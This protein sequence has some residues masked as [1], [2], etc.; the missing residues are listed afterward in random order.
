MILG[1]S[2]TIINAKYFPDAMLF[3]QVFI[4]ISI[5]FG[6]S[7]EQHQGNKRTKSPQI[8][9]VCVG[10]TS[11]FVS[12]DATICCKQIACDRFTNSSMNYDNSLAIFSKE[13]RP[14]E[15]PN[16]PERERLSEQCIFGAF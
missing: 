12:T 3:L 7:S 15:V 9:Q 13:G 5:Q 10:K 14:C 11:S 8:L 2:Y 6:G 16:T 4:R 1:V